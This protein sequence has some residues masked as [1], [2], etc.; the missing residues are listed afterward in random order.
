MI[1][2]GPRLVHEYVNRQIW[3]TADEFPQHTFQIQIV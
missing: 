1:L 2:C 3:P